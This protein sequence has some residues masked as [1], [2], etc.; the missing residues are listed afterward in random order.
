MGER[1]R[2]QERGDLQLPSS[3]CSRRLRQYLR[4]ASPAVAMPTA[5]TMAMP[6]AR[7]RLRSSAVMA[8]PSTT[9]NSASQ[10]RLQPPRT[11]ASL[12]LDGLGFNGGFAQPPDSARRPEGS[13]APPRR[14]TTPPLHHRPAPARKGPLIKSL[15]WSHYHHRDRRPG[16][17]PHANTHRLGG[18]SRRP[19]RPGRTRGRRL[20]LRPTKPAGPATIRRLAG[21]RLGFA[22]LPGPAA[23]QR[24]GVA[25]T[26]DRHREARRPRGT[27]RPDAVRDLDLAEVVI[28][29]LSRIG[30]GVAWLHPPTRSLQHLRRTC[31]SAAS[32]SH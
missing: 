23:G 6:I 31:S 3:R 18:K 27:A 22:P 21:R 17:C 8:A 16:Q 26:P 14:W 11:L 24:Q 30:Y 19:R 32:S 10:T 12:F 20:H 15:L 13:A 25:S 28:E 9:K 7:K 1:R 4:R 5:R 2:G 29:P